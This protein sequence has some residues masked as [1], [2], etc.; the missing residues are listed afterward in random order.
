MIYLELLH[1][2]SLYVD[3][4]LL[5]KLSEDFFVLT[6]RVWDRLGS[7]AIQGAL[8]VLM[9]AFGRTGDKLQPPVNIIRSRYARDLLLLDMGLG[10]KQSPWSAAASVG[11]LVRCLLHRHERLNRVLDQVDDFK[12]IAGVKLP[13]FHGE[14]LLIVEFDFFV[15]ANFDRQVKL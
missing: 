3:T 7:L 14:H 11:R 1:L 13:F 6:V 4:G 10:N 9:V 8:K 15:R 2:L 12:A 5:L